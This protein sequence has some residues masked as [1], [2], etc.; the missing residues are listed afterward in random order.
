MYHNFTLVCVHS[1]A[2]CVSYYYSGVQFAMQLRY[3]CQM[4]DCRQ[5]CGY[6]SMYLY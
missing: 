1:T 6:G 5:L 3:R 4:W 2:G